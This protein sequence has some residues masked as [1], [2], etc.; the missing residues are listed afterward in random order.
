[1]RCKSIFIVPVILLV[2][3]IQLFPAPQVRIKDIAYL[4]GIRENQLS[5][6]GLV[7]GLGGKG[8]SQGS[9]LLKETLV[10]L[11]AHFG[12]TIASSDIKSKNCA[13][14]M[15]SME[16]PPFIHPGDRV[17]VT[18]S[19][20]G[21]ARSLEE[22]ILLQTNLKAANNRIYAVAQGKVIVSSS[23][24][25]VKT[26]GAIPGGGLI[27]REIVSTYEQN[28]IIRIV[29]RHPDFVTATAV[30]DAIKAGFDQIMVETKDA[31]LIEVAV[32]DTRKDDIVG[33][34]ADVESLTLTPDVSGKVVINPNTGVIIIG[35]NV[36]IGKV[37]VSYRDVNVSVS[38]S[39][40]YNDDND[41]YPDTFVIEDTA[42]VNDLIDVLRAAG[43]KTD[44]IIG[45]LQAIQRAG[46]LY[47]SLIIM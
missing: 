40:Y 30:A 33:F 24:K 34:I 41:E 23:N 18:V 17:D 7:T 27:E 37:A 32:P 35:E 29:L 21:D 15:V 26:V 45:I 8:D 3:A 1:L 22:G 42:T 14:V 20:I 28:G 47:G 36:K 5:G 9:E 6:I 38:S 19:S 13:V 46:A 43:L 44:V 16:L 25:S 4:S 10:N 12:I 39:Y 2:A 11:L 31:A